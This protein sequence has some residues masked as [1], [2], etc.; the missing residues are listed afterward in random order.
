MAGLFA[1]FYRIM[2]ILV[3]I[4]KSSRKLD[5]NITVQMQS[6]IQIFVTDQKH[7]LQNEKAMSSFIE[8]TA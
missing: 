1:T 3:S 7:E 2:I 8:F 5:F 6:F 4:L